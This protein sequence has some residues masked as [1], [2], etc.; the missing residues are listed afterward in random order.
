MIEVLA[1]V[2]GAALLVWIAVEAGIRVALAWPLRTDFYG[3]ISRKAVRA[4]QEGVGVRAATGPGWVHLGW[5]ADPEN[6]RYRVERREGEGW[7]TV[8]RPSFGSCLLREGGGFRVW[9][10]AKDRSEGVV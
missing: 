4:V 9:C 6:E 2:V 3:S 8:A 1:T 10:V 7:R 5:I